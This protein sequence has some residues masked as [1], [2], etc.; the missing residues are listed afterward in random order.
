MI[1][2]EKQSCY[3]ATSGPMRH[4]IS[5]TKSLYSGFSPLK[6]R[7]DSVIAT[8]DPLSQYL[9][10]MQ[11]KHTHTKHIQTHTHTHIKHTK[12]VLT[13]PLAKQTHETHI[14]THT[15]TQA[16]THRHKHINSHNGWWWWWWCV[17]H[18]FLSINLVVWGFFPFDITEFWLS[19]LNKRICCPL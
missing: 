13:H 17:L 19:F 9:L 2:G 1:Y 14:S 4:Y 12:P 18:I 8:S 15:G 6:S 16:Y 5:Q 11:P 3:T 10:T 7:P